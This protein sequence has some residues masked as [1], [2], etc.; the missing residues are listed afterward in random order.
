MCRALNDRKPRRCNGKCSSPA[1]VAAYQRARSAALKAGKKTSN[2]PDVP[3]VAIAPKVGT[4]TRV[5]ADEV[6]EA[7][8]YESEERDELLKVYGTEEQAVVALGARIASRAEEVAGI[9][10]EEARAGW[11]QRFDAAHDAEEH[12][13]FSEAPQGEQDAAAIAF[14]AVYTGQDEQSMKDLARLADGYHAALAE[15]RDMGGE[16]K[17]SDVGDEVGRRLFTDASAIYPADWLEKSNDFGKPPAVFWTKENQAAYNP[18]GRV[19]DTTVA[20]VAHTSYQQTNPC[21]YRRDGAQRQHNLRADGG[22][23]ARGGRRHRKERLVSHQVLGCQ[24]RAFG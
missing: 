7:L 20:P 11:E 4:E 3:P 2:L 17:F 6:G 8:R 13:V 1:Y 24:Q 10:A 23:A 21:V 14:Q 5:L 15:V 18:K 16:M 9:T 12:A 22:A 19:A